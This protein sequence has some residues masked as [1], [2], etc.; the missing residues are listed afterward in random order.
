MNHTSTLIV[1]WGLKSLLV[2]VSHAI[3]LEEPQNVPEFLASFCRAGFP[4]LSIKP[5]LNKTYGMK[6]DFFW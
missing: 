2:A 4:T 3:L 1:P 6:Y 5:F